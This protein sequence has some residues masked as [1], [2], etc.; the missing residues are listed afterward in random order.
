[1]PSSE[2]APTRRPLQILA[3][4]QLDR[5]RRPEARGIAA[6][7]ARDHAQRERAVAHGARERADLVERAR[8]RDR[9][10][11]RDRAVGRLHADDAAQRGGLAD[12]AAGVGAERQR[13]HRGRDGSRGAA[14]RAARHA[15]AIP[16]VARR[17]VGR[18]LGR[19]AHREL[20]HVRLAELDH[21]LR[22]AAAHDG[23][24]VRRPVALE[25]AR[26][27]RRRHA[28]DAEQILVGDGHAGDSAAAF[29]IQRARTREDPLG[30]DVQEHVEIAVQSRDAVEIGPGDVLAGHFAGVEQAR[31][32]LRARAVDVETGHH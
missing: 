4:G 7:R 5:L 14:A 3:L 2:I 25:D 18:V 20:V 12:R 6:V 32:L 29:L 16:G 26:P 30:I 27:G 22:L 8:E 11:A 10:V 13:R 21:A 28:A 19:R 15:L 17:P 31:D 24:R 9:A 23:R 1:M